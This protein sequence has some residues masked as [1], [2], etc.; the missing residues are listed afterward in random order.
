VIARCESVQITQIQLRH[1]Q[2][3]RITVTAIDSSD[4]VCDFHGPV[5]GVCFRMTPARKQEAAGKEQA[6]ASK[7]QPISNS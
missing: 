3:E 4:I 6:T 5:F 2:T 7:Q 1:A